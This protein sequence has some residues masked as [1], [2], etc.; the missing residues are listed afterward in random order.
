[1]FNWIFSKL[2]RKK[3]LGPS[4]LIGEKFPKKVV[5]RRASYILTITWKG[6]YERFIFAEAQKGDHQGVVQLTGNDVNVKLGESRFPTNLNAVDAAALILQI[7]RQTGQKPD[8]A[9]I[10]E[11]LREALS[12]YPPVET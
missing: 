10:K 3:K 12:Y 1:M 8:R 6:V 4:M 2:N 9:I 11:M 5:V 7:V